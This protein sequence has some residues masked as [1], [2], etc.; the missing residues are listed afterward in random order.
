MEYFNEL[1]PSELERLSL[2]LE[3]LGEAQ[4]AIGKILRHGYEST[5]PDLP[6]NKRMSNRFDLAR[7]LGHVQR[8]VRIMINSGDILEHWIDTHSCLKKTRLSLYLHHNIISSLTDKE[9]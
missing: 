4:Q 9:G 7:E 5:N 1:S 6:L 8:A 3:E 2:L